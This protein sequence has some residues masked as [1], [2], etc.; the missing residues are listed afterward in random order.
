M[1]GLFTTL[2]GQARN[3]IGRLNTDGSLDIGFDPRPGGDVRSPGV[4]CVIVQAD[5]KILVVGSFNVLGGQLRNCIGRLNV[6]GTLDSGFN[7]GADVGVSSLAVQADGKI[8]VGGEFSTL[9]GQPRS[10]IGRLN[11]N[12]TLDSGFNPGA[13]GG[14]YVS[15][16]AVQPDGKILVGGSFLSLG[17]QPRKH[18]ARLDN[19]A[20]ATQSLTCDGSTITWLRGGTSPEVWRTTFDASAN[21]T[22]WLRLG[23]GSRIP[24][25]WRLTGASVPPGGTIR[26]RG[27]VTGG[28]KS[29]GW[30]VESLAVATEPIRLSCILDGKELVLSWTGGQGPY[31]L[32]QTATLSDTVSWEDAGPAVPGNSTRLPVGS[33]SRFLRVR[34]Q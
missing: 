13:G 32:Q 22:D 28:D 5:G 29:S 15:S 16:L 10:G 8:L 24:G 27:Y 30:F 31:Q 9:R 19:T 18:I 14:G 26:A 33:G 23:A 17:G 2:G 25:G 34:G 20:L 12:G 3:W 6:N 7:P 4:D 21:G 11:A 1:G